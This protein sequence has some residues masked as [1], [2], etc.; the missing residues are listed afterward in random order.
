[1]YFLYNVKK[2]SERHFGDGEKIQKVYHTG[3]KFKLN[4]H[5]CCFIDYF[6]SAIFAGIKAFLIPSNYYKILRC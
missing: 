2:Y 1:M 3:E 5:Q 6:L 4:F